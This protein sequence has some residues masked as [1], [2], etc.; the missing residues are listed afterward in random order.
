MAKRSDIPARYDELP[1]A[2]LEFRPRCPGCTPNA[3]AV[4]D[5]RPCSYYDCPGLPSELEVT[6]DLCMYDFAADDGQASCDHATCPTALRLAG[7]VDTYRLW[8]AM[9]LAERSSDS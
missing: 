7:N 9:L 2:V 3:L 6:C 8:V 4:P 1:P 5:A